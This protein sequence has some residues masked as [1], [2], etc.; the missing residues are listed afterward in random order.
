MSRYFIYS[1]KSSEAEDRQVLSIE[2]QVKE[3][4]TLAAERGFEVAEILTEAK[5]AKAPGRPVFNQMMQRI[6]RGEAQGIL[7]WKLDRLARNPIDGGTIIWAM[8]QHGLEILTPTQSYRQADDNVIL[9]YMEFGMAQ[10][11]ID[12]LSRNVKRGLKARVEKGWYPNTPPLGYVTDSTKP[13]GDKEIVP[14]PERFGLVKKIWEH[15]LSGAYTPP[16]IKHIAAKEWH[17]KT[18]Q[19]KRTGGKPISRST[20]YRILTNPFYTGWFEY[21]Q[22]SGQWRQGKHRPM[23][24][25]EQFDHVQALL[26]RRGNPRAKTRSFAYTGMMRCGECGSAVTAELKYQVVC[27]ECRYKFSCHTKQACPKCKTRI[28]EMKQPIFRKY[29][30]YHC[31]KNNNPKCSQPGIQVKDLENQISS[32][33]NRITLIQEFK[34][35]IFQFAKESTVDN[36]RSY[37]TVRSS[38]RKALQEC[39]SMLANLVRLKTTPKNIGGLFLSDEEYGK[40]RVDLLQEKERLEKQ[41]DS[42]AQEALAVPLAQIQKTA[43]FAYRASEWFARGDQTHKR[44]ILAAIASNLVLTAKT[45]QIT[46]KKHFQILENYLPKIQSAT[47]RIE[48]RDYQATKPQVTAFATVNLNLRRRRHDVRNPSNV[49]AAARKLTKKLFA[50]FKTNKG[51]VDIPDLSKKDIIEENIPA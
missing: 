5:S 28:E 45:L 4:E 37:E 31:T 21:P 42:S 40:Q 33:L 13:K 51:C 6:Y 17:L 26:G 30:Y 16:Q 47:G 11:Y 7:C 44:K 14:D 9:M 20:I 12:D 1:R 2:S 35:W 10:K 8:K 15:M 3:L 29:T 48:P 19:T 43:D 41:I 24:T 22:G 39:L 32:H 50:Y 25:Q 27:S 49:P 38:A 36:M 18:R 46:N 23:I 34:D